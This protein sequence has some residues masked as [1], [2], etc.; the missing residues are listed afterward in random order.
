MVIGAAMGKET[1]VAAESAKTA[2]KIRVQP[3][4][5]QIPAK[6][7]IP[8]VALSV[9][10][11]SFSSLFSVLPILLFLLLWMRHAFYKG[12]FMLRPSASLVTVAALPFLACYSIFWSLQPGRSLYA[13]AEFFAM[14]LCAVV[15][16]RSVSAGVF[17]RGLTLGIAV[18]L[19][20][21]FADGTYA[22]DYESQR[23]AL[24]GLFGSKNQVGFIAS[25]GIYAALVLMFSRIGGWQKLFFAV[26]PFTICVPALYASHSATSL[27]S[28]VL[29]LAAAAALFLLTRLGP[30]RRNAGAA[31]AALALATL[32]VVILALGADITSPVLEALGKS[33][34][35]TGRTYLWGEG[36]RLGMEHPLLGHGYAA[37]WTEGNAEAE[38]LWKKFFIA[39]KSGFHFHNLFVQGFIDLGFAGVAVLAAL[40][41]TAL[42]QSLRSV[43]RESSAES[44]YC[45][46]VAFIFLVRAVVEVDLMGPFGIGPLLFLPIIPMLAAGRPRQ[47]QP[48]QTVARQCPLSNP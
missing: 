13:G 7:A 34:T 8:Y 6:L 10:V 48:D 12:V 29:G 37:F 42:I 11:M 1:T 36:I 16:G 9:L 25:L 43:W 33:P 17:G 3:A 44:F 28:L 18:A 35:L 41:A 4:F 47:D 39:A 20:I 22:V 14:A 27:A 46:G 24:V 19:A 31:L 21:T 45:F 40:M 5:P 15:I 32:V 23:S 38:R 2:D 26:L 30:R